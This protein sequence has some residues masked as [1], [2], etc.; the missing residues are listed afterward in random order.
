M[1]ALFIVKSTARG[2][3]DIRS[4]L[5]V[6]PSDKGFTSLAIELT[7]YAGHAADIARQHCSSMDVIIAVGGDG[8]LNEVVNGCMAA[9][10]DDPGSQLPLL[11]VVASGTAN[12]FVKSTTLKGTLEEVVQLA[13]SKSCKSIDLGCV[14]Y[15]DAQGLEANRY[16]LN[17]A[18]MGI[19]AEVV[20]RVNAGEG[21]FGANMVYLK[22]IVATFFQY[23]KPM[24]QVRSDAGFSWQGRAL[25][26]IVGN[27]RSFGSGLHAVPQAVID[28]GRLH[29]VVIGDVSLLDFA[30]KLP[31]L[32]RGRVIEHPEVIYHAANSLTLSVLEGCCAMEVDGEY[33]DCSD[34][35]VTVL[36]GAVKLLLPCS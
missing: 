18:D 5:A 30:R 13:L 1:K 15:R 33:L 16:F 28:D 20:R 36:P 35:A 3:A 12:D 4:K 11:G 26:C 21:R 32:K 7:E 23:R 17:V 31:Q 8:T 19:G 34:V 9:T 29:A 27:G 25:A 24:L 10:A 22:A 6:L 2:A 14:T